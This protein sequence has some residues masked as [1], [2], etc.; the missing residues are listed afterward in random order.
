MECISSGVQ[1]LSCEMINTHIIRVSILVPTEMLGVEFTEHNILSRPTHYDMEIVL[2][3]TC[4]ST[5]P[6]NNVEKKPQD[7]KAI[8]RPRRVKQQNVTHSGFV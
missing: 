1:F 6:K 2:Y 5:T 7:L 8:I 4:H 3:K